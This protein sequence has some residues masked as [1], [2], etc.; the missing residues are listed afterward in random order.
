MDTLLLMLL[1]GGG[2]LVAY[3]TYGQFLTKKIFK[4]NK[5]A[6]VPSVE[7]QDGIDYVPARKGIIFGHHLH[8]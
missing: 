8:Q 4:L 5:N 3:Y 7:F 2:Y 1:C 6:L